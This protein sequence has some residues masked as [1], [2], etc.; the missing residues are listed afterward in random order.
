[1]NTARHEEIWAMSARGPVRAVP[2]LPPKPARPGTTR[3]EQRD[4][5]RHNVRPVWPTRARP[6]MARPRPLGRH[7]PILWLPIKGFI[8]TILSQPA[9]PN[10]VSRLHSINA[11]STAMP[12]SVMPSSSST[13]LSCHTP[14]PPP[15]VPPPP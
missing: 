9:N 1:M 14:P 15:D 7:H 8:H 5:L 3:P 6:S 13:S 10:P 2:G 4:L 12:Y 11:P